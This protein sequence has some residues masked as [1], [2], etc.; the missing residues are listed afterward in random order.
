[1]PVNRH[2]GVEEQP[3][4]PAAVAV[5]A[6]DVAVPSRVSG[7]D[8]GGSSLQTPDALDARV[9]ADD[10]ARP[11]PNSA[12]GSGTVEPASQRVTAADTSG[13]NPPGDGAASSSLFD[14]AMPAELPDTTFESVGA[15]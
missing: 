9:Q 10:G 14:N 8:A 4:A 15:V 5:G 13:S 2:A 7:G 3:T 12:L 6:G 11:T 1:M